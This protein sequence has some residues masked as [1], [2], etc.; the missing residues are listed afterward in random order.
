MSITDY[1]DYEKKL[2][3]DVDAAPV[4]RLVNYQGVDANTFTQEFRL[5]GETDRMR[6]VAGFYSG[7]HEP[8]LYSAGSFF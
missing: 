2:F 5:A 4:N 8:A 3:L 7:G 6:W 1:K